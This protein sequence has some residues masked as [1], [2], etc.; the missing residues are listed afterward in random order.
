MYKQ[1]NEIL[2]IGRTGD[3]ISKKRVLSGLLIITLLVSMFTNPMLSS[4]KS[5]YKYAK[6][7]VN[8][9]EKPNTNS[10]IVGQLYWNDKVQI[11][12]KVNKKW[13]LVQYK[14]KNRYVC[15]KYL[16]KKR[17]KYRTYQSPS[18]N[19]FKS[20]EDAN[21]IT[22]STKLAQGRLKKK[23][24]LDKSGVWMVGNMYCIAVGS[25]YT[26]KIGVKID[27]VL[28]HNGRK[29]TLK[30][31]TADSKADKDTIYNHRIHKDGSV[32]EFVVNTNSLSKKT[33]LMGDV[34]YTGKQFKGSIVKIKI[35]K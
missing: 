3:F 23:Y 8:I 27:L 11:V 28:S 13:Y 26:K 15:A 30:C 16:K 25:Y 1:C 17:N 31:I 12:K 21:C 19:T 4:A 29:H 14:K 9:R 18:S 24:H 5:N 35:Y 34:S 32:A 2:E 20:Y 33:R 6:T 7:T 22:D 10:K